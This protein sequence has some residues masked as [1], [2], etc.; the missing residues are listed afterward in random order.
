MK[1]IR[2]LHNLP[3]E[4]QPSVVTIGNFDGVHRGH[5]QIVAQIQDIARKQGLASCVIIFN[6]QPIEFFN[7]EAAPARLST[8]AE[9]L[10]MFQ[11]L[12]VDQLFLLHFDHQLA[13]MT[14]ADFIEEVL[15]PLG[16]RHLVVGKDF[17]FGKGREA[18]INDLTGH[19]KKHGFELSPA[20]TVS[21][22][23]RRISSTWIRQLL[24]TSDFA[25]AEHLLGRRFSIE[26]RVVHGD[27]RG[28]ILGF[29][30]AN[31]MMNRIKSPVHGVFATAVTLADGRTLPAVSNVGSRP[32]FSGVQELLETHIL[33]FSEEIYAEK[34]CVTF[35]QKLRNEEKFSSIEELKNQI[36][37]DVKNAREFH[38]I[39]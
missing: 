30:T 12:G 33:D 24:Q 4:P 1:L 18:G 10:K 31:L 9:K 22:H 21:E 19:G 27:K 15:C 26:G 29:P 2:G 38:R 35:M 28:R 6:P 37:I 3:S 23:G 8:S 11:S 20:D 7:P 25:L 34:I 17:R 36:G 39:N 13:S 32:V 16:I 14:A 5:Q